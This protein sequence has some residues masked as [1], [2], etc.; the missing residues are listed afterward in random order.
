VDHRKDTLPNFDEKQ[1][2]AFSIVSGQES[3]L[4]PLSPVHSKLN[5]KSRVLLSAFISFTR[6][7]KSR[8]DP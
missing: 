4:E 6:R 7:M 5:W 1:F 8:N 2:A 3:H